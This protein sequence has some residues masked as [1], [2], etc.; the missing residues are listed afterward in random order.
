MSKKTSTRN[1]PISGMNYDEAYTYLMN[2]NLDMGENTIEQ[3]IN[4][5]KSLT[6]EHQEF[7]V[8]LII[9]HYIKS[10]NET[11]GN[12]YDRLLKNIE[13]SSSVEKGKKYI[14]LFYDMKMTGRNF[15]QTEINFEKFPMDLQ[16]IIFSYIKIICNE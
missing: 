6:S 10:D 9:Y 16:N 12:K 11:T 3:F 13:K 15:S 1:N 7:I 14:H 5:M 4:T 2:K 8:T